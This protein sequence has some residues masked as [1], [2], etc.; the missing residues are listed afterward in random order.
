MEE[1]PFTE[2]NSVPTCYGQLY[3]SAYKHVCTQLHKVQT[4]LHVYGY[5]YLHIF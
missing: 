2:K 4:H 1:F 3:L 5:I